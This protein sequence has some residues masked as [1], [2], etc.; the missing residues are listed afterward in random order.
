MLDMFELIGREAEV[1]EKVRSAGNDELLG[2]Y[3]EAAALSGVASV[4]DPPP[5]ASPPCRLVL[6]EAGSEILRRMG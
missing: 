2:M 6:T 3:R 1:S 4:T 5:G